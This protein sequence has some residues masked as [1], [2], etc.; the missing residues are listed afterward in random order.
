VDTIDKMP[1]CSNPFSRIKCLL[2]VGRMAT[3]FGLLLVWMWFPDPGMAQHD[4]RSTTA[5]TLEWTLMET[6]TDQPLTH[7]WGSS[8]DNVFAA[9]WNGT[10]LHFDGTEWN[11]MEI[12][13]SG[14]IKGMFGTSGSDVYVLAN[15]TVYHYTGNSWEYHAANPEDVTGAYTMWGSSGSN[16]FV[17]ATIGDDNYI[18][19]WHYNGIDWEQQYLS[20]AFNGFEA[21]EAMTGVGPGN[22]VAGD[23]N[24][25]LYHYKQ[26]E[27]DDSPEWRGI[28]IYAEGI[29]AI[30]GDDPENI[31]AMDR[32]GRLFHYT[33]ELYNGECEDEIWGETIS[34]GAIAEIS[35]IHETRYTRSSIEDLTVV[36]DTIYVVGYF[37]GASTGVIGLYDGEDHRR[38]RTPVDHRNGWELH[39]IWAADGAN[40]FAV[41]DSGAVLRKEKKIVREGF[42]VNTAGDQGDLDPGDGVS[43]IGG[44]EIDGRPPCTFRA[45]LQETNA[46]EGV[47][48]ITFNIPGSES[49]MIQPDSA[50]PA[51]ESPVWIKGNREDGEPQIVIDGSNAGEN[52]N[53]LTVEFEGRKSSVR[54]LVLTNFSGHGVL[55]DETMEVTIQGCLIGGE[56]GN[57]GDGIHLNESSINTIGGELSDARNIIGGNEGNGINIVGE[58]GNLNVIRNNYLGISRDGETALP[59]QTNGIRMTGD[60]QK[61]TAWDNTISGNRENGIYIVDNAAEQDEENEFFN[62]NIGTDADGTGAVPNKGN[63][64]LIE[65]SSGSRIGRITGSGN[66]ISGN[67]KNGVK[68]IGEDARINR[69]AGNSIGTDHGGTSEIPNAFNGIKIVNAPDN[70]VGGSTSSPGDPPGN[71]ISGNRKTG[72]YI[73]GRE[74]TGNDIEGNLIGT[75][76]SGTTSLENY[77]GIAVLSGASNNII[78][79]PTAIHRNIISGNLRFGVIVGDPE[80]EENTIQG[81]Y[82]GTDKNG[83]QSLDNEVGIY[84]V[85]AL[86]TR[87]GGIEDE[88][89]N[90]ISG[91]RD[92]GIR[93]IDGAGHTIQSNLIGVDATGEA[94]LG[95]EIGISVKRS[96]VNTIGSSSREE[97]EGGNVISGN[98]QGMKLEKSVG[99]KIFCNTVGLSADGDGDFGNES[100]GIELY[101]SYHIQVENNVIGYNENGLVSEST[102]RSKQGNHMIRNN[103][104]INNSTGI[105]LY[106]AYRD[107]I[108]GN[109]ILGNETG[110]QETSDPEFELDSKDILIRGNLIR[111]STGSG[112]GIH[113]YGGTFRIQG[114]EITG[115][116]GD[117][118][119][120]ENGTDAGVSNNNIY[121]NTGD[122]LRNTDGSLEVDARG[123]WWGDPSGPGG[124]GSGTGDAVSGNVDFSGWLAAPVALVAVPARDTVDIPVGSG[125]TVTVFLRHWTNPSASV[126][127]RYEEER[128]WLQSQ[129]EQTV[130]LD[131]EQG[132]SVPIPV[133][134]PSDPGATVNQV[135]LTAIS[136]TGKDTAYA[137]VHLHSYQPA[138]TAINIAPDSATVAAG[139]SVRFS[140]T[141]LD[142][143]GAMVDFTPQWSAT[144]GTIEED[145]LY[146]A[147]A[148]TGEYSVTV[149][150]SGGVQ[151]QAVVQVTPAT[152]TET[153]DNVPKQFML[154][155]N[156]PNPFNPSTQI[157]YQLPESGQVTL[158]IFDLLGREIRTLLQGR[159]SAGS[160]RIRWNG[161]NDRGKRV[162][163]GLYFYRLTVKVDNRNSFKST[164]K[165]ML[166]R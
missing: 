100:H 19:M 18:E 102:P 30:W 124:S 98:E 115:D 13:T 16:I 36:D 108:I 21:V 59:N 165:M 101:R 166:L 32:E 5:D 6:P 141:G 116:A 104:I 34:G 92:D 45:A 28:D 35:F 123:N 63:G 140:A 127:V 73:S 46:L 113:L 164:K 81:N 42:V 94:P 120:F 133:Q 148:E 37:P 1:E 10:V 112:T 85:D 44:A 158:R 128:S 58:G 40:I 75:G 20:G 3:A 83:S 160:H 122:G 71:V 29:S 106:H 129:M 33:G 14:H 41:G 107:D 52:A 161:F 152:G 69:I 156:Y 110:I 65:N 67:G 49:V 136:G 149:T 72:I 137:T 134:V 15:D 131:E 11:T 126:E 77:D 89:E 78:G 125:D 31:Y 91:N 43:D 103:V 144:G 80:T 105:F 39:G 145:G 154:M 93:I 143:T 70:F 150:G 54:N 38:M 97:S 57:D 76:V 51:I 7:V 2:S 66:L 50:L 55:L 68:I 86:K 90:V 130:T 64:I 56:D 48:T 17:P 8:P 26:C 151:S 24:G 162:T 163:S 155:Q 109:N 135:N 111:N 9:G 62:N 119:T 74:A 118:M 157:R 146:I 61:N 53:G 99:D 121:G 23:Y 88:A 117:A 96:A 79:G 95:N 132:G 60:V 87:I 138:L 22:V 27:G 12:N 84:L 114:N 153:R 142:Q 4:T 159:Q 82:I 25:G 139:D 147:G 47:D